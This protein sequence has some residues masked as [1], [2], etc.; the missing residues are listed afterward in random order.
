MNKKVTYNDHDKSKKEGIIKA[1][2]D[3]NLCLYKTKV[4]LRFI[5]ILNA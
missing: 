3:M 4:K 1:E 5:I 2:N